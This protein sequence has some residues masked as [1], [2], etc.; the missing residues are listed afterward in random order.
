MSNKN[1]TAEGIIDVDKCKKVEVI[2]DSK[3]NRRMTLYE[4][5]RWNCLMEA[6]AIIGEK[7]ES[8]SSKVAKPVNW[9]KPIPIQKY[10][11]ERTLSMLF[12]IVTERNIRSV[13]KPCTRS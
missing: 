8:Y 3:T 9:I 1:D 5:A 11:D 6:V 2:L 7:C 4:F 10:I 12:E 13:F